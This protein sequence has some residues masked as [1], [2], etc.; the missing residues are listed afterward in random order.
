[1]FKFRFL[2]LIFL[3]SSAQA[4]EAPLLTWDDRELG[5]GLHVS[6]IG[7]DKTGIGWTAREAQTKD[8]PF[9]KTLFNDPEV[10]K[11][12]GPGQK[13]E[14]EKIANWVGMWVERFVI[15]KPF[16]AMPIEQDG[17]AV[18]SVQLG[19]M[20]K[21]PSV[22]QLARAF[23]PSA[24]GKGL[25]TEVLKFIVEDWAPAIRRIGL[26][27]DTSAPL[28]AMDKFKCFGG[29]P[30]KA[31]YTTAKPSNPA[32]WQCYKHFDFYPSKPTDSTVQISCENWESTLQ[33][34]LEDY[35]VSKNFSSTSS[36]QLLE[37]IL[38]DMIDEEGRKRTLSFVES[39]QSLRYHFELEVQ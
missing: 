29:E 1:M 6:A 35:L 10:V 25:G 33:G 39:Y 3:T 2:S 32:S 7:K 15:G 8:T 36:V 13:I 9:Y 11:T 27:L 22:G 26:G 37:D 4:M 5:T 18:G 21:R 28:A 23:M 34:P 31:I 12:F 16:G 30:L 19:Q 24:Q 20:N 38:Y 14:P 17:E